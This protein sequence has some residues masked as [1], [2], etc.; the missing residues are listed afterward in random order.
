MK[1]NDRLFNKIAPIGVNDI[2]MAVQYQYVPLPPL[3]LPIVSFDGQDDA[4]IERGNMQEWKQY[5]AG[6][7]M[8][9]PI[10]GD[11]YFVATRHRKVGFAL[12]N[13]VLFAT[14]RCFQN[15]PKYCDCMYPT[16]KSLDIEDTSS[17]FAPHAVA[18]SVG[19]A[20]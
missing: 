18:I 15:F 6:A 12:I 1:K 13:S 8:N 11:H 16:C 10:N 9:I 17:V 20:Y 2:M 3:D 14:H 7:F 5:T 19:H 4:T